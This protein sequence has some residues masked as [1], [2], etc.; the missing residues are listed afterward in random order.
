MLSRNSC[1]S[2]T[3]RTLRL[4]RDSPHLLTH[5][6]SLHLLSEGSTLNTCYY[7]GP[8]LRILCTTVDSERSQIPDSSAD[9]YVSIL[10]SFNTLSVQAHQIAT[11]AQEGATVGSV[12]INVHRPVAGLEPGVLKYSDSLFMVT[13]GTTLGSFPI[14][15]NSSNSG[16]AQVARTAESLST[17]VEQ[18]TS[19]DLQPANGSGQPRTLQ[20]SYICRDCRKRYKPTLEIIALLIT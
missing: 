16:V 3:S 18:A 15:A 6:H 14:Y 19:L 9:A 5:N 10:D 12:R 2:N 13:L 17:L 7:C 8:D 4:A 1:T 11:T 20:A